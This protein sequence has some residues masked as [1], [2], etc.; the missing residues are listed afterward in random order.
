MRTRSFVIGLCLA[1]GAALGQV[2]TATV[3]PPPATFDRVPFRGRLERDGVPFSGGGQAQTLPGPGC[4]RNDTLKWNG[5]A[6]QCGQPALSAKLSSNTGAP[7]LLGKVATSICYTVVGAENCF[8]RSD[9]TD[10]YLFG[11][12][13]HY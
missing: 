3:L 7:K 1:A 13:S 5:A 6:W 9:G 10:W 12:S 8:V 4:A 11:S 2:V